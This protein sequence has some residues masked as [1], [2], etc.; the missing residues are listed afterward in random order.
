M[1]RSNLKPNHAWRPSF[2]LSDVYLV[3]I[4]AIV[5]IQHH[6]KNF[7]KYMTA[8]SWIEWYSQSLGQVLKQV[9]SINQEMR[10]CLKSSPR[11]WRKQQ[12]RQ[13]R[14]AAVGWVL[15]WPPMPVGNHDPRPRCLS[16]K[17]ETRHSLGK[18]KPLETTVTLS[19]FISLEGSV[20][21]LLVTLLNLQDRCHVWST[22]Y[23][24]QGG[25][26]GKVYCESNRCYLNHGLCKKGIPHRPSFLVVRPSWDIFDM[27]CL[28]GFCFYPGEWTRR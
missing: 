6:W 19:L 4:A 15:S 2:C 5:V 28:E 1:R 13:S 25:R 3:C 24:S 14:V 16:S 9:E 18:G 12:H 8:V 23:A 7:K 17:F 22:C 11:W 26:K 21:F 27:H 20:S 10:S